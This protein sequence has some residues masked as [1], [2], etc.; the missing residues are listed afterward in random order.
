MGTK[1]AQNIRAEVCRDI[2]SVAVRWLGGGYG[3]MTASKT[4]QHGHLKNSNTQRIEL[5]NPRCLARNFG[6]EFSTVTRSI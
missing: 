1:T 2:A 5:P 3:P 4:R 6:R